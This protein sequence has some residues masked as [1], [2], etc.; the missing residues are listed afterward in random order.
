[1]LNPADVH[2]LEKRFTYHKPFGTQP[3]RYE[4]LRAKAKELAA[5]IV[6]TCPI[7]REM[8]L[9]L[10]KV[11]EACFWANASIARNEVPY[12][13]TCGPNDGCS[14]CPPK[15]ENECKSTS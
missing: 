3:Q 5:L 11:E 8:S 1:M 6:G 2:D 13:C 14:D 7:S 10:T 4:A 12:K 15:K 9:A